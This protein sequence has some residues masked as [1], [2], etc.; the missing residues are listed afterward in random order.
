[1]ARQRRNPGQEEGARIVGHGCTQGATWAVP[2]ALLLVASSP[3]RFPH[4]ASYTIL[5]LVVSIRT[6]TGCLGARRPS[7]RGRRTRDR[8]GP[9]RSRTSQR[10]SRSARYVLHPT[11]YRVG[12]SSLLPL[13]L[14]HTGGGP[15]Y[16]LTLLS[17]PP[18]LPRMI[19]L[20]DH[21]GWSS[22]LSPPLC[23]SQRLVNGDGQ[24][25]LGVEL[26]MSALEVCGVDN[27][28]WDSGLWCGIDEQDRTF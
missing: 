24:L 15:P 19:T 2:L 9:P 6:A 10:G 21:R 11:P 28:R 17:P 27:A 3:L 20:S 25:L 4:C 26:L 7:W 23:P 1:M 8:R 18:P 22:L 5:Y 13:P 12:C 14:F 16:R